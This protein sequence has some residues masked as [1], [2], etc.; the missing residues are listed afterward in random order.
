MDEC[1]EEGASVVPDSIGGIGV[2]PAA[3]DATR[4]VC[5]A[6]DVERDNPAVSFAK[7]NWRGQYRYHGQCPWGVALA[8]VI[9]CHATQKTVSL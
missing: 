9:T 1:E 7:Q 3:A 5:P 2:P 6:H 4:W 8:F